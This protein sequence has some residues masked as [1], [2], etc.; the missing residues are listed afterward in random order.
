MFYLC[1]ILYLYLKI[2][3]I[4]QIVIKTR[5]PR[6]RLENIE[7]YYTK[8]YMNIHVNF[9]IKNIIKQ[10]MFDINSLSSIVP[11]EVRIL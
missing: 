3:L 11:I 1:H 5:L 7:K 6:F 2:I 4:I 10:V 9:L 8:Y